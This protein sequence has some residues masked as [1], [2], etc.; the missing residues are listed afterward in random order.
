MYFFINGSFVSES[1]AKLSVLDLGLIRGF[2]VFDFLR[3]YSGKPFHLKEHLQRL[4]YSAKNIGISVPYSLEETEEI[5][6]TLLKKN[7]PGEYCIKLVLTGGISPDQLFPSEKASFIAFAY[8]LTGY[9]EHF[10]REGIRTI[11]T[12]QKRSLPDCK[13]T[14]YLPAI[15]SL[16]EGKK[17]GASEALYVNEKKEILEATTSNFFAFKNGTLITPPEDEILVGITREVVLRLCRSYFPVEVR[18]IHLE[19]IPYFD[20]TFITASNKEIMPVIQIDDM[21]IKDGSVGPLTK[22]VRRL[23]DC[24]TQSLDWEPLTIQRYVEALV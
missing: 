22:E 12:F 24:Y 10:F 16:K 20:E 21:Q 14:Q 8:P 4:S 19:E 6:E 23:F 13:T 15:L 11:T 17:R 1:D 5:L 7:G 2:G 18:S 9:P 3:T